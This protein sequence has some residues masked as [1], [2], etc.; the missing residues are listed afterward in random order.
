MAK[1]PKYVRVKTRDE[2]L[3]L[4]LREITID[5]ILARLPEGKLE[6]TETSEINWTGYSTIIRKQT[7]FGKQIKLK[8]TKLTWPSQAFKPY[9]N[10]RR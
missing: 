4:G 3:A 5:I 1:L 9:A 8:N 2:L 6:V 10:K 7:T